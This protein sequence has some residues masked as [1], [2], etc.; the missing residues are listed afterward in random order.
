M[1]TRPTATLHRW[2]G[3]DRFGK[4]IQGESVSDNG[5]LLSRTLKE[6]GIVPTHIRVMKSQLNT[7]KI[8]TAD[9]A[10]SLRQLS[11]LLSA[12][13][14]L[15]QALDIITPTTDNAQAQLWRD[16][17]AKVAA[18]QTLTTAF[19]AHPRYFSPLFCRWIEAG[20]ASG[21]LD[22]LLGH[23]VSYQEQRD[24][25]RK[26]VK[27]ALTYPIFIL[28]IAIII[29]MILLMAVVPMFEKLFHQL[30]AE[31]PALT[32]QVVN[33]SVVLRYAGIPI[34]ILLSVVFGSL[35]A[36]RQRLPKLCFY[37][38]KYLLKLPLIGKIIQE[39]AIAQL[40]KTLSIL[41][42]AGFPLAEALQWASHVMGKNR[43][44]LAIVSPLS[45]QLKSGIPLS[46]LMENQPLFP[47]LLKQMIAVGEMSGI[48]DKT[49]A[50]TADFY[51]QKLLYTLDNLSQL[52]EPI[53]MAILGIFTGIFIL[54]MYLPIF[55]LGALF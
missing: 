13:M 42:N 11:L 33:F 4:T 18:G 10:T 8:R 5:D 51:E 43:A 40:A 17:K 15:M 32:Q 50:Q 21:T 47:P 12:H 44:L 35:Y 38:D 24:R 39:S 49:L 22:V 53:M 46:K 52:I 19:K 26:K 55:K 2:K 48:L 9:I 28:A 1:K 27:K 37:W 14:P 25:L 30:H 29:A 31:L 20:E 45:Q 34:L 54:A 23:W 6:Q 3:R 16:C 36:H 7:K 41:L